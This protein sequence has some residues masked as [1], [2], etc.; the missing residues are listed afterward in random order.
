MIY[1]WR[2]SNLSPNETKILT[3][4]FYTKKS[5]ANGSV[6]RVT[7]TGIST[8]KVSSVQQGPTKCISYVPITVP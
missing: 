8:I 7:L 4:Y 6:T 2:D 3:Q 5:K 1:H